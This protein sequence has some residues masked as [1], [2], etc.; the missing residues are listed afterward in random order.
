MDGV[1]EAERGLEY[2]KYHAPS[3]LDVW[4]R[5]SVN[6]IVASFVIQHHVACFFHSSLFHVESHFEF[7]NP[8]NNCSGNNNL[9]QILPP[10]MV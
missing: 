3:Y 7:L 1:G 6:I 8:Y 2:Y 9:S 10:I 4:E 5:R